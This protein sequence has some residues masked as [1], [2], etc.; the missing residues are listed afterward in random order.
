VKWDETR[1]VGQL[2]PDLIA[3]VWDRSPQVLAY[4]AS[5][6][7]AEVADGVW[8]AEQTDRVDVPALVRGLH[9][10]GVA[11]ASVPGEWQPRDDGQPVRPC[12]Q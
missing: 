11:D 1:S 6:G 10:L 8:V 12:Q 9:E 5:L 7:Y 3:Q 2:Q 4:I